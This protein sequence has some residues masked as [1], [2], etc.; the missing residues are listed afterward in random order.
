MTVNV[1]E[2]AL[3]AVVVEGEALVVEAKEVEDRGVEIVRGEDVFASLEAK[4]IGGPVAYAALH[5]RPGEP[6]GEA[7]GVVVAAV[8]AGLEHR[9]AA[10]LCSEDN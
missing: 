4:L 2:T 5:A 8:G 3:D 10:E 7:V 6:G 9:H 1:G